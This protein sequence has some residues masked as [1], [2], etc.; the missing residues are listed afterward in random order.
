MAACVSF[1][2]PVSTDLWKRGAVQ[3]LDFQNDCGP[4]T[5]DIILKDSSLVFVANIAVGYSLAS[6]ESQFS[7]LIPNDTILIPDGTYSIHILD[8][9]SQLFTISGSAYNERVLT[10]DVQAGTNLDLVASSAPSGVIG[11]ARFY[12][13][14]TLKKVQLSENNGAFANVIGTTGSEAEQRF[15]LSAAKAPNTA[16]FDI[17]SFELYPAIA[18]RNWTSITW[19]PEL[20]LFCAVSSDGSGQQAMTSKNG[21]DWTLQTT[22]ISTWASVCWASTLGYFVAVDVGTP[23][24]MYSLNGVTW[25]FSN[26]TFT[27]TWTS[28]CWSPE[29]F[30]LVTVAKDNAGAS[31]NSGRV[32]KSGNA[33]SWTGETAAESNAWQSVCWS[34]ELGLFC[35]VSS[36]GT[37]RAMTSPD[38]VTWTAQTISAHTWISICWSPELGKF[39]TVAQDGALATSIDGITWVDGV[40][41]PNHVYTCVTWAGEI[42]LAVAVGSDGGLI[43]SK[44]L[45][46]WADQVLTESNPWQ[47]ITWS[48]ELGIFCILA[49][50]GSHP[51]MVSRSYS[52][53]SPTLP[54]AVSN[55][56]F[57]TSGDASSAS[58]VVRNVT[59]DDSPTNL[60]LD[61]TTATFT[62]KLPNTF[63][64]WFFK[65]NIVGQAVPTS[66]VYSASFEGGMWRTSTPGSTQFFDTPTT[67][68]EFKVSNAWSTTVIADTSSDAL[69]V[70]VTGEVGKTIQW[71]AKVEIVQTFA[72]S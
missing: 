15:A 60:F 69:A 11:A 35:A 58:F 26:N 21:V 54:L 36:D 6:G 25:T 27:N 10:A 24:A 72:A 16:K 42:G 56:S 29:L 48:P 62:L 4:S 8:R 32:M 18:T 43:W 51:V 3:I 14:N 70:Q 33:I 5:V 39:I 30:L 22:Q 55:G 68:S 40:S 44:D 9:D 66:A 20:G 52:E 63:S 38:A 46:N 50:S 13:N 41:I 67:T 23:H 1:I 7:W 49:P 17:T 19:S 65:V 61:G 37:H 57:I 12:F 34:P 71:V 2:H 64:S 31:P 28:V 59:T 47:T 45:T 53:N